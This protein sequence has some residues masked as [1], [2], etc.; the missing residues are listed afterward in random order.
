[1]ARLAPP[2]FHRNNPRPS[3]GSA[4]LQP[5]TAPVI[6]IPPRYSPSLHLSHHQVKQPAGTPTNTI[7]ITNNITTAPIMAGSLI[8]LQPLIAHPQSPNSQLEAQLLDTLDAAINALSPTELSAETTAG[9]LDNRYPAGRGAEDVEAYLW[10]LWTLY[11]NVAKKVPANDVR[12]QL[13]VTVVKKLK[14]KDRETLSLWGNDTKI[15]SDLPMLGPCMR[16][17]WNTRPSFNG[18]GQDASAVTEWISLN[19]FAARILGAEVQLWDN[20]AI[21]ELRGVLEEKL[22][23]SSSAR[24]A[25][26]A[27]ACEWITHAGKYI[28]AKGHGGGGEPLDEA[29]ARALKPGRLLADAKPGFSDERW[30]FWRERLAE[31]VKESSSDALKEQVEQPLHATRAASAAVAHEPTTP[32][33]TLDFVFSCVH[34]VTILLLVVFQDRDLLLLA[35]L[36]AAHG[37]RALAAQPG[38]DALEVEAVAA[39]AGQLDDET[40]LVLEVGDLADGAVVVGGER[41]AV[42]AVNGVDEGLIDAAQAGG[43]VVDVVLEGRDELLEEVAVVGGRRGAVQ[44]LELVLQQAE[45]SGRVDGRGRGVRVVVVVVVLLVVGVGG[46]VGFAEGVEEGEEGGHVYAAC[47]APGLGELDIVFDWLSCQ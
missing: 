15:W 35:H 46:G 3:F 39:L 18:T 44:R 10:T 26:L 5:T 17:A 2:R 9:E 29:E 31:L 22:S 12:Q 36:L 23:T 45:E 14:A 8:D 25:Q 30:V 21:W 4:L 40:P 32:P 7:T 19:S 37:A 47:R 24:D 13:L 27:A 16:E 33:I 38:P 1:M 34:H 41:L 6:L 42:D 43:R 20:F 28:H 11:L